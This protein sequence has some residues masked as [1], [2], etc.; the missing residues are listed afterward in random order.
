MF[1]NTHVSQFSFRYCRNIEKP[2]TISQSRVKTIR[3]H[4]RKR[5]M[6]N[7]TIT[8]GCRWPTVQ[9]Y[10]GRRW[11]FISARIAAG[12]HT[13]YI[14]SAR[15]N[16]TF[17]TV[18]LKILYAILYVIYRCLLSHCRRTTIVVVFRYRSV[19]RYGGDKKKK[20][21]KRFLMKYLSPPF[22][23]QLPP[24]D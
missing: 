13:N 5:P 12:I 22:F 7:K 15:P 14:T 1:Y 19:R 4:L 9:Y 6:C 16:N 18:Y 24:Y 11:G 10:C 20:N 3:Y 17:I 23:S 21:R 2:T 8:R